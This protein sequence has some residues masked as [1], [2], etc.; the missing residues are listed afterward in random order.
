MYS[1]LIPNYNSTN[2]RSLLR[3]L[4][5][6]TTEEK[7][8]N[9]IIV[10]DDGSTNEEVHR[11]YNLFSDVPTIHIVKLSE[12]RGRT[13]A[14]NYLANLASYPWLLFMDVDTIPHKPNFIRKYVKAMLSN[15]AHVIFGGVFF[16]FMPPDEENRRLRYYYGSQ[17][18]HIP[19]KTREQL[20]HVSMNSTCFAIEKGLFYMLQIPEDNRYGMDVYF[21]YQLEKSGAK[22]RHIESFAEVREIETNETFI[23]KKQKAIE[24]LHYLVS[25]K[26][27]PNDYTPLLKAYNKLKKWNLTGLYYKITSKL[28]PRILRNLHS[29]KPS[30]RVFNLYRLMLYIR[31][32]N[33]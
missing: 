12:N 13:Y 18:E 24:T 1:I 21:A 26:M 30:V 23:K 3:M 5:L 29:I 22:I 20:V 7:V 2:I 9:E 15:E 32:A 11:I 4:Y 6:F 16:G 14:R 25:R 8:E 33:D 27:I 31:I 28:E 17:S 19:L 10:L